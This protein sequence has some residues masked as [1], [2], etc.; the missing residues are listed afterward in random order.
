M[1]FDG[2]QSRIYYAH[3]IQVSVMKLQPEDIDDLFMDH[4]GIGKICGAQCRTDLEQSVVNIP[5]A[6]RGELDY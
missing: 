1:K 6:V 3:E 4:N 5:V 2:F